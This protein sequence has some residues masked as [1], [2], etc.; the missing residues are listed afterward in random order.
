MRGSSF[1]VSNWTTSF[2][3]SGTSYVCGGQQVL[4]G[5][6][7]FG[8]G[9]SASKTYSDLISHNY[10]TIQYNLYFIDSWN[11]ENY[12]L[13]VDGSLFS[14]QYTTNSA[15]TNLCGALTP[16]APNAAMMLGPLPHSSTTI[17]ITFSTSMS[18]NA[19]TQSLGV[20]NIL[21]E[22]YYYCTTGCATCSGDYSSDE[23]LTCNRGYYLSGSFCVKNCSAQQYGNTTTN[24]CQG[25]T[26]NREFV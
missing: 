19:L 14:G 6:G 5:Y 25:T 12:Y 20:L 16:D 3:G 15:G 21:I 18:N 8:A 23:C 22:V 7:L 17:N 2:S 11:G 4:G 9:A 26:I 10:V 24:T 13:N 1:N